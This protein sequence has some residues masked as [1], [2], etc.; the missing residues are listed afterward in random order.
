MKN[1]I[2][3]DTCIA[4]GYEYPVI[5]IWDLEIDN[6]LEPAAC[7]GK[8]PTTKKKKGKLGKKKSKTNG[9]S[10]PVLC[11]GWNAEYS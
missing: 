4:M 10:G 9:H 6:N 8:V 7:L 1:I 3:S 2:F 11:L 5:D